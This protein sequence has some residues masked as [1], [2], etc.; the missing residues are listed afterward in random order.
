MA[1]VGPTTLT[2]TVLA[3]YKVWGVHGGVPLMLWL[4]KTGDGETAQTQAGQVRPL[5]FLPTLARVRCSRPFT[6]V[7]TPMGL[8]LPKPATSPLTAIISCSY[9][10]ATTSSS[11]ET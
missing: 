3:L 5:G 4:G 2:Q 7:W 1:E 10:V 8:T 6:T 11:C 9:S